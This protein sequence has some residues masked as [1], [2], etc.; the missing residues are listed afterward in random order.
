MEERYHLAVK[1]VWEGAQDVKQMFGVVVSSQEKN[2][3]DFVSK[4]D[5]G[6]ESIMVSLIGKHFPGDS[7]LS[8]ESGERK[9]ETGF[10]WIIDPLDG[11]HNFLAGLWEWGC[12]LALTS[13]NKILFGVCYFPMYNEL[14]TAKKGEGAFRNA[15]SIR[16]SNKKEFK[17]QMFFCDSAFRLAPEKILR[18]IKRF[19]EAGCRLRSTGSFQFN[20]TRLA[21]GQ[22]VVVTNRA[23]KPWDIGAVSLIVEEAG[24]LVT[25]EKGNPWQI[26]SNNILATNGSVHSEALR[27]FQ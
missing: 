21:L 10:E 4:A 7:I 11:T 22:G 27:I 8:E 20:M 9:G 19:S 15:K 23:A 18:D 16:V 14:F 26:N 6:A 3:L 25:D 17:G 24:G 1:A 5:K 13:E 12:S 2:Y